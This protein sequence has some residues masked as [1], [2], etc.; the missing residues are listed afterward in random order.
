[1]GTGKVG[2]IRM[3]IGGHRLV[4]ME[5]GA[6]MV[7]MIADPRRRHRESDSPNC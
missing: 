5:T 4:R 3:E 6:A 2:M 1:M 7:A